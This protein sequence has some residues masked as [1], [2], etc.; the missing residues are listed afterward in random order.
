MK[1]TDSN[2]FYININFIPVSNLCV[3]RR[4]YKSPNK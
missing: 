3:L 2:T 4:D 1:D